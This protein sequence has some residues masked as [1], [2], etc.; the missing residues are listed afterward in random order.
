MA[1]VERGNVVLEVSDDDIQR[2]IDKGYNLTDGHGT[3]IIKAIPNQVGELQ[4]LVLKQEQ[5]IEELKKLLEEYKSNIV[6]TS[7][8]DYIETEN[9]YIEQKSKRG[10]PK[11]V[12]Q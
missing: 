8:N 5:E 1:I 7:E 9:D 11:K 6:K 4:S 2:Y 3:V 12:K 10:R